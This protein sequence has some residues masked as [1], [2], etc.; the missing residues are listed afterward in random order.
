MNIFKKKFIHASEFHE[1][2][3]LVCRDGKWGYI[4]TNGEEVIPLK[5]KDAESFSEGLALVTN[6]DDE[7]Y[8]ININGEIQ[9][10]FPKTNNNL[11][12]YLELIKLLSNQQNSHITEALNIKE[13]KMHF[14]KSWEKQTVLVNEKDEKITLSQEDYQELTKKLAK[15][16]N[17]FQ[18]SPKLLTS[19][20]ISTIIFIGLISQE[21]I[22]MEQGKINEFHK[23]LLNLSSLSIDVLKE[24]ESRS[25]DTFTDEEYQKMLELRQI[26]PDLNRLLNIPDIVCEIDEIYEER[27][28]NPKKGR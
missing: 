9:K 1:G 28:I 8:F 19:F 10:T 11:D 15:K 3:A 27:K 25:T 5:Y 24:I 7:K 6:Q 22:Y 14:V 13:N 16:K 26:L 18:I 21:R 4:N 23:Q 12:S 17:H 20:N 2:L